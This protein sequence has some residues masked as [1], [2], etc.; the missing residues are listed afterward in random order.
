MTM[1]APPSG[2][3]GLTG[4]EV[5]LRRERDGP[6]TVP[7]PRRTPAWRHLLA[8][9]THFFAAML[10]VAA[11]L[12]LLAGMASLA[13]AI[14]I[15]VILNGLFA[16]AQEH[17]AD[18]AAAELHSMMPTSARVRRDGE[19][20]TVDAADLVCDDVVLVEAGDRIGADL[21]ISD[22][23]DL[24]VDESMLTGRASPSSAA[25]APRCSPE[26]SPSRVT[27]PASCSPPGHAPALRG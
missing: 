14:V 23:H 24:S 16:F 20:I 13:V 2:L 19:T 11:V 4:A 6:N 1:E 18:R 17:K 26:R 25:T 3:T 12:A 27:R 15:I 8:Q 21:L 5:A 7:A 9:M 22:S 10:W